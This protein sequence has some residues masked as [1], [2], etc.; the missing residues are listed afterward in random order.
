M[1]RWNTVVNCRSHSILR[2]VTLLFNVTVYNYWSVVWYMYA[3]AFVIRCIPY[4]KS[5]PHFQKNI[6]KI[7]F[8]WELRCLLYFAW[9]VPEWMLVI[10]LCP[11]IIAHK[12]GVV[13]IISWALNLVFH[14]GFLLIQGQLQTYQDP[15]RRGCMKWCK[16]KQLWWE[17]IGER[18]NWIWKNQLRMMVPV[19]VP[20]IGIVWMKLMKGVESSVPTMTTHFTWVYILA[21][22]VP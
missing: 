18:V 14:L 6:K 12:G 20:L 1:R 21:L 3:H 17:S 15:R 5:L 7:I 11:E 16:S 13:V 22:S 19:P 9:F 4:S 8:A 2:S 10:T